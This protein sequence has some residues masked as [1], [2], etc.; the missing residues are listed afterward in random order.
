MSFMTAAARSTYTANLWNTEWILWKWG[1]NSFLLVEK[2]D[3][4]FSHLLRSYNA[5][6][7]AS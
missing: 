3:N 5:I 7:A 6:Q 1:R 2:R 4:N